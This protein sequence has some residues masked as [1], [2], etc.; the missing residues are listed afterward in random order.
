[1]VAFANAFNGQRLLIVGGAGFVGSNLVRM[2]LNSSPETEVVVIDNL[3]SSDR[4]NLP[5]DERITFIE[6]SIA[7]PAILTSIDDTFSHIFHLATY[8]GNQSSIH[9]PIADHDNNTLTTLR[10]FDHLKKGF[11]QL[12]SVVYSSAGCSVA[13][14]TFGPATASKEVDTVSLDMDSPYSISKIIGEFYA[15]YYYKEH[16]LP[17]IRAR[18]QNVYGPGEKLGAGQWRGTPA[19]IWRNVTPTF[20]YKAL[21]SEALPLENGGVATRDFIYVDDIA[22]GLI[23]CALWG[24]PNA[25]YNLAT[26]AEIS[27]HH[28]A[29]TI[30][31][32]IGNPTP[33]ALQP[34]RS[35]DN[36]GCRYG[37]PEKAHQELGFTAAIP[38]D[39][40]LRRTIAW[41]EA[42]RDQIAAAI[43]KQ[44]RHLA[45][46][47]L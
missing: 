25:A 38:L 16:H 22:R 29:K 9:D 39:E 18:F 27:I 7:D 34:K 17:I 14:K 24:H 43:A 15:K 1:M 40:G 23:H 8:H 30:N 35:W 2:V 45:A 12:K 4:D 3:L 6:G 46:A 26:G 19:T 28:L 13:E 21:N 32:L 10:L 36:S 44:S 47:A 42:H 31:A 20:I 41:T 11:S 33:I 37:C 5:I